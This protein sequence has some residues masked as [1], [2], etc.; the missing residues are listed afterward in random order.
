MLLEQGVVEGGGLA[1]FINNPRCTV[2]ISCT[3][4]G[5]SPGLSEISFLWTSMNE[6]LDLYYMVLGELYFSAFN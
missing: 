2:L 1:N 3:T 4:I 6:S 5:T